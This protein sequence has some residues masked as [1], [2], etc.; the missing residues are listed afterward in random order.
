[1]HVNYADCCY[2]SVRIMNRMCI[3]RDESRVCAYWG[4]YCMCVCLDNLK[5]QPL[6]SAVESGDDGVPLQHG[7]KV[8]RQVST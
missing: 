2:D 7:A 8:N 1:M 3:F 6:I 4:T 5:I